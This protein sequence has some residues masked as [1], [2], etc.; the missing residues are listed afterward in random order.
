MGEYKILRIKQVSAVIGLSRSTIYDRMN[1]SSPRYDEKFPR[2]IR[3]G[4][5]SVGWLESS[6]NE[7]IE[8]MMGNAQDVASVV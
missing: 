3:I 6:L 1:P 7:W 2:P 4:K 8:L 5:S